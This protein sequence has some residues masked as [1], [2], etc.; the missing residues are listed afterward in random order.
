MIPSQVAYQVERSRAVAPLFYRA[1]HPPQFQPRDFQHAGVEYALA[2]D[3][4]LIGDEPGVGKTAQGILISN[5]INAN[6]TLVVCPASLRLNW[7]RE[8]W[9]IS[10]RVNIK[11]SVVSKASHGVS[12]EHD[13]VILSYDLLRN[14]NIVEAI[15][16]TPGGWDHV[17]LDEAHAIKSNDAKRM[18]AIC[19]EPVNGIGGGIKTVAGRMTLLSGTI[20]PNQP[21]EC[22]NAI[23]LLDWSAIDNISA[24]EFRDEYYAMG[25]GMIRG[26][27]WNPETKANEFKLHWSDQVRNVPTNLADLQ[28]RLRSRI[29][30]RR[31][32]AQVHTQLPSKQFHLVPL[33]MTADMRAAMRHPGWGQAAQLYDIDPDEFEAQHMA[34]DGAVSTARR[35]LGEAKA[36]GG[37]AYVEELLRS[38]IQKV[39]VAA[40]HSSVLAVAKAHL[41]KWGLCYMDGKTGAT[42]R[43]HAVD[44][45]QSD[46]SKRVFL[47]QTQVAGEG[48]TLTAAQDVVLLEPDWVPGKL[49]QMVDR[50]HRMGQK[51][52]HVTAHLL[53]A[54]D[55]LDEKIVATAV[56][57]DRD[58]HLA[59][60][61][62]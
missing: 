15:M 33:D 28:Q 45:F 14:P 10:T 54:P 22:Y 47:G 27:V 13:Y 48:W 43:Q 56:A 8:I 30:I 16:T 57:K 42:A 17:I 60:D 9:K 55:T 35:A 1:P 20:L 6:R 29:M 40:W 36:P 26:K 34:V 46:P 5:A 62:A 41:S 52:S 49:T 25:G 39:V 32:K 18:R 7:Q 61:A 12:P 4:C 19:V 24:D 3:H 2:R 31:L 37:C 11:T 23:R 38:G 44:V 50:C 59:L 21:M 58:I 53:V 51:G